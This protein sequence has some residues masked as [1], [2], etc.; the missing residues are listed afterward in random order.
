[1]QSGLT[2]QIVRDRGERPPGLRVE[3]AGAASGHFDHDAA[4]LSSGSAETPEFAD[5]SE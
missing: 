5:E 3:A 4:G 2:D 1:V